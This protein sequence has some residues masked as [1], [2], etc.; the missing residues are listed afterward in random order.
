[1]EGDTARRPVSDV[2]VGDWIAPRLGTFGGW[3]GSV[4]PHGFDAY[5]RV[6]HPVVDAEDQPATWVDVCAATGKQAHALMQWGRIAASGGERADRAVDWDGDEPEPG[7]LAP[8]QFTAL[9]RI[10]SRHTTTP[11]ACYFGLWDGWGWIS[12]GRA[13]ARMVVRRPGFG[14]R[15][16]RML[17]L[18]R[19]DERPEPVPP[20]F[21][22]EV[23]DGPR[24]HHPGRDYILFSGSL[25]GAEPFDEGDGGRQSPNLM[26]PS[27]RAWFVGS[28]IDFDS[29]LVAGSAELIAEVLAEPAL[30]AWIVSTEDCLALEGD[31]INA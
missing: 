3:V 15:L 13:V 28:E 21:P 2:S 23:L 1:M 27:D 20:A 17:G 10:L 8:E 22:R 25:E 29:T 4:V 31:T 7:N 9:C 18:L 12:G 26:W 19:R 16:R 14:A 6:L 24:L 11:G 30:D 5:A